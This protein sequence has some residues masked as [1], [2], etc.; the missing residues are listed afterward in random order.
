MN[1]S[2]HTYEWVMSHIWMS[3]V[4]HTNASRHTHECVMA[5]IWMSDTPYFNES[6]EWVTPH[7][8]MRHTHTYTSHATHMNEWYHTFK[9]VIWVRHT[10]HT[11]QTYGV[12]S[13]SRIDKII[14]LFCKR[15]LL[16]RL[17]SAKETC[18]LIDPTNRR[19][20]IPHIWLSDTSQN[21]SCVWESHRMSHI[22]TNENESYIY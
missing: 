16:K 15:A 1:E 17:Y 11:H 14:G 12:A 10:S 8:Y 4:T 6:H 21:E 7:T 9:G 20:P 2:C 5:Y 19:H 22:F 3:H 18:S 13:L